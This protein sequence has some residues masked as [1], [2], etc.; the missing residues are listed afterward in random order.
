MH[1]PP[2]GQLPSLKYL[3]V[4]GA[5]NVTEIGPELLGC[6]LG[7]LTPNEAVAFPKLEVL[8][9]KDM[10]NWEEWSFVEGDE[11]VPRMQLLPCVKE[12]SVVHCPK[13]RGLPRQLGQEA[14]KLEAVYIKGANC[15]KTVDDLP[16]LSREFVIS[17]CEGL[18]RIS[19][20]P[21]VRELHL[22]GC[23]N[24]RCVD[25]VVNFELLCLDACM[26]DN[27]GGWVNRLLEQGR[28]RLGDD[29]DVYM[30]TPS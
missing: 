10:P 11:Q 5:T 27:P 7:N 8:V 16:F 29:L 2:I 3:Q 22:H 15:L 20:L 21:Q 6:Y 25:E 1:L 9:I 30:L 24:L 17:K 18:E 13:L 19:N 14:S 26:K 12:V 28:R 23:P 4:Q